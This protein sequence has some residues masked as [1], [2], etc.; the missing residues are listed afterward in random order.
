MSI[1]GMVR[2]LRLTSCKLYRADSTQK[3]NILIMRPNLVEVVVNLKHTKSP[4][5]YVSQHIWIIE[6][7]KHLLGT[8]KK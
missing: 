2:T 6:E 1:T 7:F 4:I 8:V 5:T 3:K